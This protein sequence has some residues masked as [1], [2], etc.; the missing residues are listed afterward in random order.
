[1]VGLWRERELLDNDIYGIAAK[2]MV[3]LFGGV[4]P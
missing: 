1:M 4:C 2:I 3:E